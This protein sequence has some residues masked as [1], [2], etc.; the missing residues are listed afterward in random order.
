MLMHE[1]HWHLSSSCRNK[2]ILSPACRVYNS[3]S[4]PISLHSDATENRA[5]KQTQPQHDKSNHSRTV[6]DKVHSLPLPTALLVV[7][8][9]FVLIPSFIIIHMSLL[10]STLFLQ[11]HYIGRLNLFC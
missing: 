4:V 7:S 8:V 6:G 10:P 3:P 5:G 1:Q 2:I 9:L 11:A